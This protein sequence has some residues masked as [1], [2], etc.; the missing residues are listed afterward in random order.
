MGYDE[1]KKGAV[2]KYF[3]CDKRRKMGKMPFLWRVARVLSCVGVGREL[4][5]GYGTVRM[6][7]Y[8]TCGQFCRS[9][10]PVVRC[11]SVI[12]TCPFESCDGSPKERS[13]ARLK[14][15]EHAL[16]C[17]TLEGGRSGVR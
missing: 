6:M 4:A 7:L 15:L 17:A 2:V 9:I 1:E 12:D 5:Y 10:R 11:S 14:A 16:L 8:R 13:V 3:V